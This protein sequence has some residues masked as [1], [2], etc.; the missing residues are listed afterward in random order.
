M[1]EEG[2]GVVLLHEVVFEGQE[3]LVVV[4]AE[5]EAGGGAGRGNLELVYDFLPEFARTHLH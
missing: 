3:A 1:V 4:V 5:G 2:F